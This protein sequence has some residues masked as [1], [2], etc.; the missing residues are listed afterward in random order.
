MVM[1]NTRLYSGFLGAWELEPEHS[2]FEQS[3]PPQSG[4]YKIEEC[5]LGLSF[6][7]QWIDSS[8]QD[9]TVRFEGAPD[10][11]PRPFAGGDLADALA[12]VP[13]SNRELKTSAYLKGHE[14]MV[15]TH[16][17]SGTGLHM[18][19]TQTVHLPDGTSPSN[20]VRYRRSH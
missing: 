12:V 17:L 10:G 5:S 2:V 18:R 8:G 19:L 3:A 11:Q 4:A 20:H 15:A 16:R 14:L 1:D 6:T 13:V 9:F 7:M